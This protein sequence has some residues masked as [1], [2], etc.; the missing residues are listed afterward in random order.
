MKTSIRTIIS[1]V[2]AFWLLAV[3]SPVA[4]QEEGAGPVA[5][6]RRPDT[7]RFDPCPP[8]TKM[9]VLHEHTL[10]C[11]KVPPPGAKA[12]K[13]K[14]EATAPGQPSTGEAAKSGN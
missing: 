3:V 7:Q 10:K 14:P 9:R 1:L 13:K 11:A 8:G 5:G 2:L 6:E 12:M 4:A